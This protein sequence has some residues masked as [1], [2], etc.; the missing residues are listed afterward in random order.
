M[1]SRHRMTERGKPVGLE[2]QGMYPADKHQL[3]IVPG[4]KNS[5][6]LTRTSLGDYDIQRKRLET[7]VRGKENRGH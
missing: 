4:L 2:V 7:P 1:G 6:A 3:I 5:Q